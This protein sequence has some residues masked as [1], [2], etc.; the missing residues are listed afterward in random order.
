MGRT[1]T[2]VV[3]AAGALSKRAIHRQHRFGSSLRRARPVAKKSGKTLLVLLSALGGV[4]AVFL[5]VTSM[6]PKPDLHVGDVSWF[7]QNPWPGQ[8]TTVSLQVENKGAS[9][10]GS[11]LAELR[12]NGTV[13]SAFVPGIA[14]GSSQEVHITWQPN[15]VGNTTVWIVL[16]TNGVVAETNEE[17]NKSTVTIEVKQPPILLSPS[18]IRHSLVRGQDITFEFVVDWRGNPEQ[19]I[20][21]A[22]RQNPKIENGGI[23]VG[24]PILSLDGTSSRVTCV[25]LTGEDTLPGFYL[26]EILAESQEGDLLGIFQVELFVEVE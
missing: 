15:Q 6:S 11:F 12:A 25:L 9:D 26:I 1:F 18:G 4:S 22:I 5:I 2:H 23:S 13:M 16:D 10:A 21:F 14:K 20:G 3:Q 19:R 8:R 24:S 7:P 17:N